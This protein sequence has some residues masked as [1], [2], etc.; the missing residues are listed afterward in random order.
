[1]NELKSVDETRDKCIALSDQVC[2]SSKLWAV[3]RQTYNSSM[4]LWALAEG[5][6]ILNQ[7]STRCGTI[8]GHQR[9]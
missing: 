8:R 5:F 7:Y 1:M 4:R 2:L 3:L 9:A 6:G